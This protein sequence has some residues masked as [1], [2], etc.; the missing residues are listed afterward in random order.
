MPQYQQ[1]WVSTELC[2]ISY[3]WVPSAA[4]TFAKISREVSVFKWKSD[5]YFGNKTGLLLQL[6]LV[7]LHSLYKKQ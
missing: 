3:V 5:V 6:T 4:S 2:L 1:V 7:Y